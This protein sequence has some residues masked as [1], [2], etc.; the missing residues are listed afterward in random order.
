MTSPL[1]D[2]TARPHDNVR[3]N[4]STDRWTVRGCL[5]FLLG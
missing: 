2:H 5:P 4:T 1:T 3:A